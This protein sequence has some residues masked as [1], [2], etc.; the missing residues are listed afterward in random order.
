[1][2]VNTALAERFAV[3]GHDDDHDKSAAADNGHFHGVFHAARLF[4]PI[5][6]ATELLIVV[7]H[8]AVV[9]LTVGRAEVEALVLAIRAVRVCGVE[10]SREWAIPGRLA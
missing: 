2:L 4:Q 1:M 7:S 6:Q 8:L 9:M 5:K 10:I 3:I